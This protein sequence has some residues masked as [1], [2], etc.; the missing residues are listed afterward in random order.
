VRLYLETSA[1]VKVHV[2]EDGSDAVRIALTEAEA[3]ATSVLAYVEARAALIRRRHEGALS[4][5]DYARIV[6]DLD[7]D[8][9]HYIVVSVTDQLVRDGARLAE[10]YRLRAH[11]AMHLAS[12][13]ALRG[14]P[15]GGWLFASWD[16]RLE[17]AAIREGF[18]PLRVQP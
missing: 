7:S 5:T 13:T 8:W 1:L 10:E 6:R 16:R 15:A 12:A 4:A 11:G 9:E 18:Q 3:V 17:D 2:H 14:E